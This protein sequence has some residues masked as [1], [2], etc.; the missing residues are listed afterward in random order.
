MAL[1]HIGLSLD[2][3]ECHCPVTPAWTLIALLTIPFA[4]KAIR[5]SLKPDDITGLLP[6]M[7]NNVLVVLVTQLLLGIGYILAVVT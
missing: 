1:D 6:A 5:G 7:G 4:A 2:N 3:R